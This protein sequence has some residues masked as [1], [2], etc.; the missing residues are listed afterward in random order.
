MNYGQIHVHLKAFEQGEVL[1][2]WR[3]PYQ[4]KWQAKEFAK[5]LKK[6]I[7][8]EKG[9]SENVLS[10]LCGGDDLFEAVQNHVRRKR[11]A[12]CR[13]VIK[14]IVKKWVL[15]EEKQDIVK[16]EPEAWN[17]VRNSVGL[18]TYSKSRLLKINFKPISNSMNKKF[19]R[20]FLK[21]QSRLRLQQQASMA[22]G[23]SKQTFLQ[24]KK[25]LKSMGFKIKFAEFN[26]CAVYSFYAE[27]FYPKSQRSRHKDKS[28][29]EIYLDRHLK[30]SAANQIVKNHGSILKFKFSSAAKKQVPYFKV[31]LRTT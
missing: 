25:T 29:G 17:I 18:K 14:K 20:D 5:A 7:A 15:N 1:G 3:V 4:T 19:K 26:S 23:S 6:P 30:K 21:G 13:A 31:L 9:L 11:L 10:L 22:S 16:S 12:D 27:V 28:V 2:V 24:I 8:I